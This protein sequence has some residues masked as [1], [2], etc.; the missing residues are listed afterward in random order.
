MRLVIMRHA[1]SI[2]NVLENI[3]FEL[4]ME[5]RQADPELSDTGIKEC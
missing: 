3:S 4:F 2:M 5:N 1:E